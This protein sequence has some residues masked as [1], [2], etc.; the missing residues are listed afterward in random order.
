MTSDTASCDV[1]LLPGQ[2]PRPRA[3]QE[4]IWQ[5]WDYTNQT[6]IGREFGGVVVNVDENV[7]GI[8][9]VYSLTVK[10]YTHWFDRHLVIAW[11]NQDY[12][13]N[14]V[15]S[16]VNSFCPGFTTN[17]VQTTTA[18]VVPQYFNYQKASDCVKLV[19]DQIGF[20]WYVDYWKDVHF[21]PAEFA[22]S[23]LPG[24]ILD[25]DNDFTSYGDL[26][27][28]EN[29]EQTFNKVFITGFK[30][31]STNYT[32]LTFPGDGQ[33]VQWSLGYRASS[34]KGDVSV[35][36]FPSLVAYQ[37]DTSFQ[38]TGNPTNG[39]LLTLKRDIVDGAPDQAS[40]VGTAYIH[41]TQH[42]IRVPNWNGTGAPASGTVVAAHFYYLRDM[43]YMGQ[44]M[45]AQNTI[46]QI[47][48]TDGVYE[49]ATQDKSL[50]NSTIAAAQAK[51]EMLV[52]KYGR[53]Q[54]RGSFTTFTSKW[55]AGQYFT[56]VTQKR[57]DGIRKTMFV[58]R[59]RK[60][61]IANKDGNYVVQCT[62][63][64]ADSPYLV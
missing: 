58:Q 12:A 6:E 27:L 42:L 29:G 10:S 3:G 18:Q 47:E 49:Y 1:W 9:L 62:V 50:T 28:T 8:Y 35:A 41:Y 13:H 48:G 16:I 54:L 32:N 53:P 56:L 30:T 64:F 34:V 59:V 23:P 40:E 33:T 15:K 44:D 26:T 5:D 14:V 39:T 31:R 2:M 51:A 55:R 22:V 11:Y 24:N 46:V 45:A 52:R 4:F 38:T 7:D 17:N 20:G 63:E 57:M 19:A 60:Q 36:V 21:Y 61:L 43:V 25:V 37:S